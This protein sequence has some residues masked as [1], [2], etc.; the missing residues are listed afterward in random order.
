MAFGKQMAG[1]GAVALTMVLAGTGF[2]IHG[3]VAGATEQTSIPDAP[4]PQTLPQ[5]NTITPV[6]PAAPNA[7]PP[8]NVGAPAKDDQ[9]V[10]PASL[11]ASPT[12]A[13]TPAPAAPDA[14][15]KDAPMDGQAF[16][17]APVRVNFVQ[18]P[19][20]V[21]DSKNHLVPGL[22]WRDVRIFENGQ[23]Q[24]MALFT[25]DPFPIS[26]ALVID[27]TVTFDTMTKIN[28]ALGALQGAFAPYD[29]VA[30]FT[31]NSSVH[32]QTQPTSESPN[33]YLAAQSARLGVIIERSKARGTEPNMYMGGPLDQTLIKNNQSVD[34]NTTATR[35][36][37]GITINPQKEFHPLDDAILAAAE[38][39]AHAAK[40][41]RRIVY[42]ISDGKEYGSTA[43]EKDVIK[44]CQTN[45]VEV[46]A[47]LV[48][49]SAVPGMG[50]LDRIHLPLT[51][52][53]DIL[54]HV[55][56]ATGGQVDLEFRQGGIEKSF[57]KI[58][59]QVRTQYTIGFYTHIPPM[60]EKFR[61]ID[62]QVMRGGLTVI[63]EKG[64][65]PSASDS[66]PTPVTPTAAP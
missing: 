25:V 17:L 27:Q 56:D 15:E 42:V 30:V 12:S 10:P 28:N 46:F 66:A 14:F 60:N 44:Y 9:A 53:D 6:G 8:A 34:P 48:G 18:I 41:R 38:S 24:H 35:N 21:K 33:G 20:T 64:Y 16:K 31:Y 54:P 39:L 57:A 63:A 7:P 58:T 52:R 55:T 11:P 50:F 47:T 22:T 29:E 3:Q 61:G 32:E 19:F 59:E 37:Q 40:G 65:Y 51:M 36:Q 43:K 49:D 23:R 62:V 2:A 45:K 26:V 4:R 5:L 1:V 13:P